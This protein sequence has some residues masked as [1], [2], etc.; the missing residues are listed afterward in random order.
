MAMAGH[1]TTACS[2]V[3]AVDLLARHPLYQERLRSEVLALGLGRG[4]GGPS[5]AEVEQLRFLD[6]FLHETL[7]VFCPGMCHPLPGSSRQLLPMK[8]KKLC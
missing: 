6:N 5:Y 7:R 4:A 1:D 2:L 8:K 3:W